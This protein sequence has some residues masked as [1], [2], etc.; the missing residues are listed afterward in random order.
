MKKIVF[1]GL[2]AFSS[3][4]IYVVENDMVMDMAFVDMDT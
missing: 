3:C 2:I 1:V 4:H